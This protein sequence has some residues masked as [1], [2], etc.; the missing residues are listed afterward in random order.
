M[1]HT[2]LLIVHIAAGITGLAL[3]PFAVRV[4][5]RGGR[6]TGPAAVYQGAVG[7]LTV[8]ALGLVLLD[9]RRLWPFALIALATGAAVVLGR[10]A[11][12]LRFPGWL[13]WHVRLVC[14]SYVSLVTALLVVSWGSVV[15]WVLPTIVGATLVERAAAKAGHAEPAARTPAHEARS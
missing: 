13:S 12:R 2:V 10:S 14:G 3:G 1:T 4:A 6:A 15:A 5:V 8:T 7:V 9:W 11:A